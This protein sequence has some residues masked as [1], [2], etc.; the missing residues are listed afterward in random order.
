[1][2]DMAP[3]LHPHYQVSLLIRAIPPLCLAS[4]LRSLWVF[5]LDGSLGIEATGSRVPCMRLNRTH[6][7]FMPDAA[8]AV[9]RFLQ[10]S[11][12]DNDYPPVLT[13]NY[14][15]DTSSVVHLRSSFR[16]VP[17]TV[18]PCL[19]LNAHHEWLLTIAA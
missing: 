13:S 6:A 1:M 11:S 10:N 16:F 8:L 17:D 18:K 9:S 15:F 14:A 7:T 12:R 2:S 3:L 19:F 4:V 5:H